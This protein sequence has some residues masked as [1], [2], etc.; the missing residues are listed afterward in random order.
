MKLQNQFMVIKYNADGV[1]EF[2]TNKLNPFI[3]CK[4]LLDLPELR[5]SESVSILSL[6]EDALAIR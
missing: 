3:N 6:N 4:E 2:L 5:E 1:E